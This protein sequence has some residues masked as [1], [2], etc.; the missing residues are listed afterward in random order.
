LWMCGMSSS[1]RSSAGTLLSVR[2]FRTAAISPL[3]VP[4]DRARRRCP[5]FFASGPLYESHM[6]Y[7]PSNKRTTA[8][9]ARIPNMGK[10]PA[11]KRLLIVASLSFVALVRIEERV[12]QV[13]AASTE[14]VREFGPDASGLKVPH[15]LAVRIYA[16]LPESEN[17][18]HRHDTHFPSRPGI[19]LMLVILR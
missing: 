9:K 5:T 10:K 15:H 8:R 18:L 19:S 7:R 4:A 11:L 1:N 3:S 14:L 6:R 2:F 16:R 17:F 12:R 13:D